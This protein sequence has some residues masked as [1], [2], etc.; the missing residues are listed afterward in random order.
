MG[1][2]GEPGPLTGTGGPTGT[3]TGRTAALP[4]PLQGLDLPLGA[5]PGLP[6]GPPQLMHD[7]EHEDDTEGDDK[8]GTVPE[9]ARRQG[10]PPQA[11]PTD[12]GN[13]S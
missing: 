9:N 3:A 13:R 2:A 5:L 11:P 7:E 1:P 10:T 6:I 12:D 4:L 8:L